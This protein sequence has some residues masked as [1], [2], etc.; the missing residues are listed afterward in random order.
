M[1]ITSAR[2]S[3]TIPLYDRIALISNVLSIT[4]ECQLVRPTWRY[5]S[6]ERT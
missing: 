6:E 3:G 4:K 1:W 5:S 2:H